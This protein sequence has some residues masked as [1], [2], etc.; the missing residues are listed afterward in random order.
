MGV[1]KKWT[2]EYI[3]YLREV[4]EGRSHKEITQLMSSK[5]NYGFNIKQIRNLLQRNGIKT[6]TTSGIEPKKA[7][8]VSYLNNG[9][10][11]IKA[12]NGKWKHKHR[13]VYEKHYGKIGEGNYIIFLD[14]DKTNFS[15]DNLAEVSKRQL[16]YINRNNLKYD[17]A[18]LSK[19][20]MEVANLMIKIDEAKK[21]CKEV[22]V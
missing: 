2:E 20:G 18:E 13:Y 14:G 15:I 19:A 22:G 4:A 5:F 1:H 21:K 7:D 12:E 3:S 11:M 17:D 10:V 9:Y 8:T 16:L 6:G